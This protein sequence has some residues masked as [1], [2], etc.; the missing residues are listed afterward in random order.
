MELVPIELMF[1]SCYSIYFMF[2][3]SFCI[4]SDRINFE[5]P[6]FF[7]PTCSWMPWTINQL[8][9][10][11]ARQW[12]NDISVFY[13]YRCW[14]RVWIHFAYWSKPDESHL[15]EVT[16]MPY[17]HIDDISWRLIGIPQFEK[18]IKINP[19]LEDNPSCH[20]IYEA[21]CDLVPVPVSFIRVGL[22]IPSLF[23]SRLSIEF[24]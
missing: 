6:F 19:L 9:D 13:F 18:E 21:K 4:S 1:Y 23:L 11:W 14:A 2:W 12:I 7:V 24:Q 22:R 17:Q 5:Y 8:H 15:L 3:C 20:H 10:C 16:L